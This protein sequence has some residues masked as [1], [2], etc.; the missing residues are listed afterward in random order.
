MELFETSWKSKFEYYERVYC[1]NTK[2]SKTNKITLPSEWF[3]EDT[4]GTH[5][6]ILNK[7]VKLKRYQ[8]NAKDG[9]E[10]WGFID[11]IYRNIRDKYWHEHQ[12]ESYNRNPR[13]WYLDIETRVNRSYVN[14]STPTKIISYENKGIK[15]TSTFLE[16]QNKFYD[17]NNYDIKDYTAN[18]L[19][20]SKH[21]AMKRNSGFPV[22]D[23][24]LEE[25]S[26]IQIYDNKLKTAII[27]GTREWK[28]QNDYKYDYNVQYI[29][30]NNEVDLLTK[31][32]KVFHKLNPL[33]IYAWNGNGFDY[34]YIRN[35]MKNL[36]MDENL[37]SVYGNIK[38]TEKEYGHK[39]IYEIKADGHYYLDLLEVYQKFTFGEQASY[40]LDFTAEKLLKKKK[41]Q[42]TE[43]VA[44]DDFYTGK[45]VI[46]L[47][48]TI[49][50]K[51]SKIY[52]A[53]IEGNTQ[54]VKE[55]AHSDF[56]HYGV[57]DTV[58]IKEIDNKK[59][60]TSLIIMIAEKMGVTLS[61]SM[62]TV[63]PWSK[64]IANKA[65]LQNKVI[66]KV[67][68]KE[69]N[70]S[71]KGGHVA[72]PEIGLHK[73]TMSSDVNSMYPLLGMVGFNISPET[74]VELN[75]VPAD[76]KGILL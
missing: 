51:N 36:G 68:A 45:Y 27:F 75:K 3:K 74:F 52:K 46:P 31:Y 70:I 37:L 61:D 18:L 26:L 10:H 29:K 33:I 8:G 48:P 14:T 41:V 40:S 35:R 17:D 38:Y 44:F 22:P 59:N 5:S 69:D 12:E 11:P 16:L 32:I 73:W 2:T 60:F 19:P 4:R 6:S 39:T 49:T 71:I 21:H 7:S 28:H 72:V 58:I 63:K 30:C 54:E 76:L 64:F 47:N 62:G 55:L 1:T 67:H 57:I 24:A 9:R 25:I 13:I 66:P 20:L 65:L 23:K 53:A 50:Q 15:E 56:V 43:Y 34:P 42:H